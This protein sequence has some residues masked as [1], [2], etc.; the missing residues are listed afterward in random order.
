MSRAKSWSCTNAAQFGDN[1]MKSE[2]KST[3]DEETFLVNF[4]LDFTHPMREFHRHTNS[5]ACHI[6]SE[7]ITSFSWIVNDSFKFYKQTLSV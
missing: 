1:Y 6:I 7:H 5:Q 4:K 2:N 3:C